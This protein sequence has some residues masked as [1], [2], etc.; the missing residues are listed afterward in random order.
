MLPHFVVQPKQKWK[1]KNTVSKPMPRTAPKN[2][3]S[4]YLIAK[5]LSALFDSI[6]DIKIQIP[7]CSIQLCGEG[8]TWNKRSLT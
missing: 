5:F 6:R 7:R 2:H 8:S 1:N 4:A 3:N